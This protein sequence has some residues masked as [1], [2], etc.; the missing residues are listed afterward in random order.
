MSRDRP[1][2]KG[3]GP[4]RKPSQSH[5]DRSA[6]PARPSGPRPP[7]RSDRGGGGERFGPDRDGFVI[8]L[9]AALALLRHEPERIRGVHCWSRDGKTLEALRNAGCTDWETEPPF[10]LGEDHL[11]QGVALAIR[12]YR[13][14]EL[15]ALLERVPAQAG[16]VLLL[17]DSITDT[18]NVGAILRSAAFFGVDGAIVPRDRAAGVSPVAE[19]IAR[20]GASVVPVAQVT[21]L[22][23]T[24]VQL[25]QAGWF[26]IGTALQ[27]GA[28]SLWD[29][30]T[31][32]PIALVLGAEDRG[33]RPLV[34][35]RCDQ[36]VVLPA[37]GDMQSLNVASF[38]TAAL[39]ILRRPRS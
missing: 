17:L 34:A 16:R 38:A 2:G 3:R 15:D 22:A 7:R 11:A 33:I 32:R 36:L 29:C 20:G 19:R 39:A 14:L 25:Q 12:P 31:D 1:S 6:A 37:A 26:C 18:R 5:K 30:R 9:H 27:P 23:Q 4:G 10:G 13:H 8:G 35:R 28:V 24:I 21:N